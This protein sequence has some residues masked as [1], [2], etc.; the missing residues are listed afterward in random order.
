[1]HEIKGYLKEKLEKVDICVRGDF[2]AHHLKEDE[3]DNLARTFA[4]IR[5]TD[6]TK[7]FQSNEPSY[8][9]IQYEKRVLKNLTI[10]H[11]ILYDG[12]RLHRIFGRLLPKEERGLKNVHIYSQIACLGLLTRTT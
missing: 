11:G 8:G 5:V 6:L 9:E 4:S 3:I 7:P 10:P 12:F 2:L 1:M